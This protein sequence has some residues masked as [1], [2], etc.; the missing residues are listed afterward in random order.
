M[1]SI[2]S[3][4]DEADEVLL[5]HTDNYYYHVEKLKPDFICLGYDQKG[6]SDGLYSFIKKNNLNTK[7]IRLNSFYP[8][9]FKS[10]KIKN[11]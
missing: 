6:A 10:S 5:G 7:I 3:S 1:R 9:K 2:A 4:L 8:E 11:L